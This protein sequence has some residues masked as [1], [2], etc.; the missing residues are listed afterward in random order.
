M[1]HASSQT[2]A[3]LQNP[4][5][6][7]I[8]LTNC[9]QIGRL[10][11][12]MK[13]T[14]TL[15]NSLQVGHSASRQL[16]LCVCVQGYFTFYIVLSFVWALVAAALALSLPIIESRH[17]IYAVLGSIL[18]GCSFLT[19][20]AEQHDLEEQHGEDKA[21]DNPEFKGPAV[22]TTDAPPLGKGDFEMTEEAH[23]RASA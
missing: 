11:V 15:P 12:L 14:A 9:I 8:E 16:D 2:T 4:E 22:N 5:S 10:L 18:P 7:K 13:V 3:F 19:R 6:C 1:R 20:W 21:D 17:I 23:P